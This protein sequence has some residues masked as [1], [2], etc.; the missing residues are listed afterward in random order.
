MPARLVNL[1]RRQG[2]ALVALFIALGG[3]SFAVSARH[4]HRESHGGHVIR[5]CVGNNTGTLRVVDSF[6]RCGSLE[7]PISFN[8]Q[9]RRGHVGHRGRQGVR[10]R[11]GATGAAGLRG[12]V[13]A[14][15]AAGE[16]GVTGA[17]GAAGLDAVTA[18]AAE[19]AGANCAAGGVKL[20][21]GID[22]DRNGTLDP[23]E[24]NDAAT[25]YVCDG[26]KGDPGEKGDTGA[27]GDK[28]DT[29]STGAA[30]QSVTSAAE[31]PGANCANGGVRYTS[32]SG[33][34]YVCNGSNG[35]G[36]SDT[37][38]QTLAKLVTVDGSGSGLDA[39]T[40]DGVNSTAL[41]R[42]SQFN[43]LFDGALGGLFGTNDDSTT[44]NDSTDLGSHFLAEVYL[45]AASFPPNGTAFA[46]G[47]EL[48]I[49]TNTALFSLIGTTYGGDGRN[50]FAL[51][52]LRRQA[53]GGLHY[54][55]QT[56]GVFPSRP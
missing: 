43:D 24:V 29:G 16:R 37:A 22:A 41:V 6:I 23:G 52:D 25:R 28:G 56:T 27:K 13:G 19:P 14:R 33:V 46:A 7:T 18:T 36:G 2:V 39:D 42:T 30:G 47:Q 34:N 38:A 49:A 48:S 4:G 55:I 12:P 53:P 50:T 17:D 9:G 5:G 45:T 21:S 3:T 35:T 1:L 26:A 54:V 44:I 15:G 20:T 40:L 31:A 32:A 11:T 8:R 51:P 10:G